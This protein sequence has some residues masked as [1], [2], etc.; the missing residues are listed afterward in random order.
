MTCARARDPARAWRARRGSRAL[1]SGAT[2]QAIGAIDALTSLAAAAA[3]LGWRRPEV[4][5]GTR[6]DIKAGRHPLVEQS[7]PAGVFVAN[8]LELDPDSAQIV[9]PHR[10]EHGRQVDLPAPVARSSSCWPSAAASCPRSSAVVGL[11]DRIFTRVGAHDDI[12]SGMSTFMVEMTETAYILNHATRVVARDPRRGG[13][14]DVDLRRRVDRAGGGRAPARIAAARLPHAVRH[15][16]S[17]ADGAGGAAAA[18]AQPA[19]RGAR[20]GRDG[21]LPAPRRAG[22]RRP[23]VRHSR[24]GPGRSA[25]RRSS[26]APAAC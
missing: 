5:A 12:T 4:N 2:A 14:G 21:A 13:E 26:P 20:G 10:A 1:S 22:R 19:R 3:K 11:A 7:L 18:R 23:V 16:L 15:P 8:D 24:R 6:L 17:R 9:D 25:G